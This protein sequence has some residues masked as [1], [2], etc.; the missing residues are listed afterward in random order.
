MICFRGNLSEENKKRLNQGM[1]IINVITVAILSIIIAVSVTIAVI[2]DDVIWSIIYVIIPIMLAL[3][4]LPPPKT[5]QDLV[6]PT[7]ICIEDKT[8]S[9][10][11]NTFHQEREISQIKKIKDVGTCYIIIFKFPNKSFHCLC[12]KDLI[13]EGTLEQFENRFAELIVRKTN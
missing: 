2:Y 6:C 5:K 1:V 9:I 4:T 3:S 10:V 8:I 12:Q 13:T 11:G 7:E